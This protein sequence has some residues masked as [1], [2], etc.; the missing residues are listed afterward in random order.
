MTCQADADAMKRQARH[1]AQLA[2]ELEQANCLLLMCDEL[3]D[4]RPELAAK[5]KKHLE[6]YEGGWHE[7]V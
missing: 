5:V 3:H 4:L 6:K 1:I 2:A 7:V